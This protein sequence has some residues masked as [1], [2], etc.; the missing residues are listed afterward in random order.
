MREKQGGRE[1]TGEWLDFSGKRKRSLS[2]VWVLSNLHVLSHLKC[3]TTVWDKYYLYFLKEKTE[4]RAYV[5]WPKPSNQQEIEPNLINHSSPTPSPMFLSW[6]YFTSLVLGNIFDLKPEWTERNS[7]IYS[8]W[9]IS[10]VQK[11]ADIVHWAIFFKVRF[12]EPGSF[13][14][15]LNSN[16]FISARRRKILSI[17]DEG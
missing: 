4:I 5:I 12:E 11:E 14:V 16:D 17:S 9:V 6:S 15:Y 3:T 13:H 10:Q 7:S 8:R 1:E 2:M